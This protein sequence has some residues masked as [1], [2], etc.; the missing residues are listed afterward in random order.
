MRTIIAGSRDGVS[1]THVFYAIRECGWTP[2]VVISGTA[3]GA[4]QFGERAAEDLGIKIERFPADWTTHGKSAGFIRNTQ[5]AEKA[6]ALIAI[7]D[8]KSKGTMNMISIANR[9]GLRIFVYKI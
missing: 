2:S 3:R 1:L 9:N 6:E 4:D 5:M 8:G 7:W